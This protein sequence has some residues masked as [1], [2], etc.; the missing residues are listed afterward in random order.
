MPIWRGA[1]AVPSIGPDVH[2]KWKMLS[3]GDEW[4]A[5]AAKAV[6]DARQMLRYINAKLAGGWNSLSSDQRGV[7]DY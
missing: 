3:G 7:G 6:G 5:G 2:M 1:S 4:G